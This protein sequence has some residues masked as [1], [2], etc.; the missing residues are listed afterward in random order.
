VKTDAAADGTLRVLRNVVRS[1]GLV[2]INLMI[3]IVVVDRALILLLLLQGLVRGVV[4]TLYRD[5]P[6]SALYWF[7]YEHTVLRFNRRRK[8]VVVVVVS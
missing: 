3:M 5:V 4:P 8:F 6:F 1:D 2:V 7:L